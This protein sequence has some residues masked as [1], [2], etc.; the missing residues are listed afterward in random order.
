MHRARRDGG[1][2]SEGGREESEVRSQ[3][4][5]VRSQ[6]LVI[7]DIPEP[8]STEGPVIPIARAPRRQ[9]GRARVDWNVHWNPEDIVVTP[10][11]TQ[12]SIW[13][14]LSEAKRWRVHRTFLVHLGP[15]A[16]RVERGLDLDFA[17]VPR[18]VQAV[19]PADAIYGVAAMV[20]DQL[21]QRGDVSRFMADALLYEIMAAE[22]CWWITRASF[23][24]A[25]RLFGWKPWGQY[26]KA[27]QDRKRQESG[28]G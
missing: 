10:V 2:I 7:M 26:R 5:E 19:F 1:R 22:H 16:I 17:S 20:H 6:K 27:E 15:W 18:V 24:L 9:S 11:P 23:F 14:R 3:K 12:G 25:V 13:H 8:V 28:V 4:S 21:Y